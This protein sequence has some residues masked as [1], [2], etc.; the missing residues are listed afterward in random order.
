MEEIIQLVLGWQFILVAAACSVVG[1]AV[2]AVP[3][4][5]NWCIPFINVI[6]A[7]AAMV[8]LL[9]LS[10]TSALA[11]IIAASVATLAYELVKQLIENAFSKGGKNE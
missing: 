1:E 11:G 7:V 3:N 6:F 10:P 8:A 9:G 4:I 5:P 2:K